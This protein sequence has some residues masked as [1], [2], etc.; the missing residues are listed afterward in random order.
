MTDSIRVLVID[1]HRMFAD[2]LEMLLAGEEGI[3]SVGVAETAEDALEITGRECPDVVLMDIDLPGMD[4]IEAT[5]RILEVCPDAK[6]V[7][8]TALKPD[9]V[10]SRAIEAGACGFIAK[11][12]AADE[13]VDVIR[14]AAEGEMVL[15]SGDIGPILERLQA[16]RQERDGAELLFRELT[17]RERE[18][19]EGMA[20]AK[21]TQ[22][23]AREL[24]ISPHTV[25]AH[26]RSILSKLGV[27]SKLE[28]VVFALKHGAVE[29][30]REG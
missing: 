7:T 30:A 17:D 5:R 9:E 12:R 27:H 16:T 26:V 15:P 1:D 11:T 4:G 24:Y 10:I 19:L 28:A 13:L 14:K 3:E 6:V 25:Q 18:I 20:Q 8:I 21:S 2:A 29:I 22:E 23:L